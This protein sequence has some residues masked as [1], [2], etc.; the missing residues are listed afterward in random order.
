MLLHKL[1]DL[2]LLIAVAAVHS[3]HTHYSF[4]TYNRVNE[5]VNKDMINDAMA[6]A[7]LH[8]DQRKL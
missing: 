8:H 7:M 2:P 4:H 3:S 5:K 6:M 1:L